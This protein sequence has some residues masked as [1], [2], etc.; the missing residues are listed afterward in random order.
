MTLLPQRLL[1]VLSTLLALPAQAQI[2]VTSTASSGTGTLRAALLGL[3]PATSA[4]QEI[5]FALPTTPGNPVAEIVLDAPLPVING[6]NVLINGNGQTANVIV[7]GNG[8]QIFTVEEAATT[9]ALEIRDLTLRGGAVVNNGG[10]L[11]IRRAATAATLRRV[12][13]DQCKAYVSVINNPAARGGAVYTKGTLTIEDSSFTGNSIVS[14]SSNE[15]SADALGGAL[16]AEGDRPVTIARSLFSGNRI[17]LG[18]QLPSFCRSGNGGAIA[19]SLT[20]A[21]AV[22]SDT[23]FVDNKAS[24][25][26]PTVSYDLD[27][28]GDGGAIAIYGQGGETRLLA[29]YFHGNY[30]SRGGAVGFMQPLGMRATLTN[31]TFHENTSTQAGGGAALVNCCSLAMI[32]NT[33]SGNVALSPGLAN[34]FQAWSDVV[35]LYNNIFDG[36]NTNADCIIGT[37]M[38][39]SGYNLYANNACWSTSDGTSQIIGAMTWLQAPRITGGYVPTMPFANGSPPVDRGDDA[40]C[41]A[42][43]ARGLPRPLDGNLDGLSHCDIGAVE[44]SYIDLIFRN[45]FQAG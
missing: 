9:T 17:Y 23:S 7:N 20:N 41:A 36:A 43:D 25:R 30:G 24:C 12:A 44:H 29:N 13:F 27:G 35:A 6:V 28:T 32:N 22:I 15:A 1:F 40:H 10:C 2:W 21:L 34:Q 19:L 11:R 42:Y 33:F 4:L 45:G 5:R 26:N 16:F 38:T 18:N 3:N 14:T 31:N 37:A 39:N 8:R